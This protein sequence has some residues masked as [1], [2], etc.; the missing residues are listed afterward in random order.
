MFDNK[1]LTMELAI[2]VIILVL[3]ALY[4]GLGQNLEVSSRM[5]TRELEDAERIQKVRIV[6]GHNKSDL[7][8]EEWKKAVENINKIDELDI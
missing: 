6:K 3:I 1:E 2:I 5:L 8:E 4:Y 7:K